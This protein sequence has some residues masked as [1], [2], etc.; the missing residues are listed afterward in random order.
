VRL[1]DG[2]VRTEQISGSLGKVVVDLNGS[3]G[4]NSVSDHPCLVPGSLQEDRINKSREVGQLSDVV[5]TIASSFAK[6]PKAAL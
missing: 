3:A 1:Q 6:E 2:K 5:I 4:R